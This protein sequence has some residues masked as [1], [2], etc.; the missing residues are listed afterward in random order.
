MRLKEPKYYL[1]IGNRK[2][3]KK[4]EY[5]VTIYN[6]RYKVIFS[7]TGLL[8]DNGM[9]KFE[10]SLRAIDKGITQFRGLVSVG[11]LS[12][13]TKLRVNIST[14]TIFNWFKKE[15]CPKEYTDLFTK[16]LLELSL[17]ENETELLYNKEKRARYRNTMG[18]TE[19]VTDFFEN[20]NS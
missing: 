7:Y 14:L 16:I 11:E 5:A 3:G 4:Q 13:D 17:I 15:D 18:E 9:K 20:Y 2:K 12:S 8:W 10:K 1:Y 19:K 6:E